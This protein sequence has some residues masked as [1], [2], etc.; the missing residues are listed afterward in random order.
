MFPKEMYEQYRNFTTTDILG[1]DLEY[2]KDDFGYFDEESPLY[3]AYDYSPHHLDRAVKNIPKEQQTDFFQEFAVIKEPLYLKYMH[4]P[5]IHIE[6][7]AIRHK[8]VT[9]QFVRNITT[10]HI[11]E[12]IIHHSMGSGDHLLLCLYEYTDMSMIPDDQKKFLFEMNPSKAKYY[13]DLYEKRRKEK[14]S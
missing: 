11:A 2:E 9:L 14:D 4:N 13:F 8:C 7:L 5:S 1:D 3:L 12:A 10:L 6:L